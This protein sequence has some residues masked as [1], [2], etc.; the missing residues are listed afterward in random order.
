VG[1]RDADLFGIDYLCADYFHL[2]ATSAV[3]VAFDLMQTASDL[4][5]SEARRV[6]VIWRV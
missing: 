4:L 2:A 1:G 6:S 5:S 3:Q